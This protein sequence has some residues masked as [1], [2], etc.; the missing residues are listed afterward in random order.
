MTTNRHPIR[1]YS[2]IKN[3][4]HQNKYL[5]AKRSM[6]FLLS[7]VLLIPVVVLIIV[8]AVL[9]KIDSIGPVF[10]RGE[11]IGKGMQ[12]FT[13]LKLRTMRH[14]PHESSKYS[15]NENDDRITNV[16]RV[17]RKFRIDEIPQICNVLIG[18]M[19]FIG[20]RPFVDYE[21]DNDI[22]N[23]EV[24]TLVRPG[25]SGLAQVRGG[26]DLSLEEKFEYDL[27]YL[28]NLSFKEDLMIFVE[29]IRVVVTG[30]GAR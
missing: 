20:P 23:F 12:K 14:N 3:M 5:F 17:L 2:V 19:S 7:L 15:T 18:E 29:T 4:I 11:R 6:D 28:E 22:E 26:N 13:P 27:K 21:Y 16:G 24:R 25:I 1:D 10:Y 30:E 9:I 8:L